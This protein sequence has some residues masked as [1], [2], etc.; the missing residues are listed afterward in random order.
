MR[1]GLWRNPHILYFSPLFCLDFHLKILSF[2]VNDNSLIFHC[3]WPVCSPSFQ[4]QIAPLCGLVPGLANM[5][6]ESTSPD[7]LNP[8]LRSGFQSPWDSES[9]THPQAVLIAIP[10]IFTLLVLSFT[11]T[12]AICL[13]FSIKCLKSS[14]HILSLYP[15]FLTDSLPSP[16]Y[17]TQT[18]LRCHQCLPDWEIPQ[19]LL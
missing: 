2:S 13:F 10:Q 8:W 16:L 7:R 11:Q 12:I 15:L 3:L 9:F 18:G 14:R 1:L 17:Y 6:R 5:A 4:P 19:P